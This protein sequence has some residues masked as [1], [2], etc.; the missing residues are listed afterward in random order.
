[1]LY[2]L[3]RF[4]KRT[5]Q[6][7]R[8]QLVRFGTTPLGRWETVGYLLLA[9]VGSVAALFGARG[10]AVAAFA[11][12]AVLLVCAVAGQLFEA[13]DRQRAMYAGAV[14]EHPADPGAD[15]P[16][17]EDDAPIDPGAE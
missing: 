15:D 7:A 1:M 3:E 2:V 5:L 4:A 11:V 9:A 14:V 6:S 16:F 17:E 8:R 10:L 12:Y 13:A